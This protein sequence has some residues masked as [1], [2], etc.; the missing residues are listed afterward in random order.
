[1][2]FIKY[3]ARLEELKC[4]VIEIHVKMCKEMIKLTIL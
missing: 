3:V 2:P 1:M 4:R